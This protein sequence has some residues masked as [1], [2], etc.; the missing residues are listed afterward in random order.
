MKSLILQV[1]YFLKM[2]LIF[3]DLVHTF[4]ELFSEKM[5][6]SNRCMVWCPT[7]TKNLE[8]SLLD[9]CLLIIELKTLF[10]ELNKFIGEQPED[11]IQETVL[12]D[13]NRDVGADFYR[14]VQSYDGET[15]LSVSPKPWVNGDSLVASDDPITGDL[16]SGY[17]LIFE[18]IAPLRLVGFNS[19]IAYSRAVSIL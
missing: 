8:R 7:C 3:V 12:H 10:S 14:G 1:L 2:S 6:I 4:G 18:L 13:I 19:M 16:W 5:F 17:A 15:M 11:W 9:T